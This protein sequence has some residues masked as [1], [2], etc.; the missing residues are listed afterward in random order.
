MK[1][2]ATPVAQKP[3]Q[4]PYNLQDPLK[5][6][7]EQRIQEDIFEIVEPGDRITWCSPLEVQP[8]P[9]FRKTM[10]EHDKTLEIVLRRARDFGVTFNKEKCQFGVNEL[11]FYGYIFTKD[12][13]KPTTDKMKTVKDCKAP[14]SKEAVRAPLRELT[15]KEMK[16]KWGKQENEAFKKHKDS[17][18]D[19]KTMTFFDPK[20]PIIVRT[21]ASYHE[22]LSAGLFQR[23]A[24]G[25]QPVH[26][27]SRSM[28]DTE[29]RYSQTE[30]DALENVDYELVYEPGKDEQDPLDYLSRHPLP[31]TENDET[32]QIVKQIIES[33]HAIVLS[34]IREET[35]KDARLQDVMQRLRRNDWEKHKSRLEIATYYMVTSK[36]HIQEPIKPTKILETAWHTLAADYRGPYPDGHYNLAVIDKRMRYPVV[37][38]T[39]TTTTR[40]TIGKLRNIFSTHEIPERL[41]TDNG[42]S[43]S[44]NEFSNFATE[45]GFDHHKIT[46][47]HPRANGETEKVTKQNG[48]NCSYER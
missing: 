46:P 11:E 2:D 23:T 13:L 12:E 45:M 3:R 40:A 20:R 42:P 44:S 25:L 26:F 29:K 43:F 18:T 41:E 32:E 1:Q 34:K 5:K 38:Q 9:R 47:E 16:F 27:I 24:K 21:E 6:W 19:E 28:I 33:E 15:K 7:M 14:E 4:V 39:K 48:T 10:E 35:T 22:G 30:K 8:K 17:I 36:E 31:E 37:E